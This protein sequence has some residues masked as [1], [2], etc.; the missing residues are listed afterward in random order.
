V[1]ASQDG[2]QPAVREII[3]EIRELPEELTGAATAVRKDIEATRIARWAIGAYVWLADHSPQSTRGRILA[4]VL[5]V[6]VVLAP[7]V[8]LL[9]VTIEA[10][11]AATESWFGR[12]GYAGIFLANLAGTGT[13]FIPVPG[14][15]AAGQAL[16]ISSAK[17]LS[18][19]TVGVVGGAGMAI[20]EIT[21]YVAGMAGSMVVREES[22]Q[23]PRAIRSLVARI[24]HWVDWLMDHYGMPTL[25]LLAAVPNPLFEVAGLT[26]GASRFPFW[27][28]MAA[29]L[30][31][32]ITRGL[33]LAYLGEKVIFG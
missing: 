20:G 25:F 33:L 10:G 30:S 7:S 27:K 17:V 32:K 22:L 8:A 23:A 9:Y 26:A 16:I 14:V 12:Y 13:L 4:A 28:F 31:G 24:V 3:E 29:V 15:T 19:F 5:L 11:N 6:L 2:A 18:P 1:S 21:A